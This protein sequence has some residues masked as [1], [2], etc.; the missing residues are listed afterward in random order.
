MP[1][2]GRVNYRACTG[3]TFFHYPVEDETWGGAGAYAIRVARVC[4]PADIGD[5]LSA[6][7][8]FSERVQGDWTKQVY[9]K[10]G[11]YR[12]GDRFNVYMTGDQMAAYCA[13][14]AADPAMPVE[15]RGGESWF[16]SSYHY[17]TY[18][19]CAGPNRDDRT[20]A[21][22]QDIDT[23]GGRALKAGSFPAS[24]AHPGG[25]NVLMLDGS[26]RFVRDAIALPNW[27]ALATRAGGE[28]VGED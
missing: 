5:G 28:V 18:N 27:R 26:V 21:V 11:D 19:H 3:P 16:I 24:S 10:G 4:R 8:G 9:R 20:C 6:T 2:Y 17:T 7:V 22:D 23:P 12:L 14:L 13:T 1:G 15:S 25:V